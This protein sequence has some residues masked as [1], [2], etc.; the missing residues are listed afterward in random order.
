M[1]EINQNNLCLTIG[2]S[3]KNAPQNYTKWVL[4]SSATDHIT[5]NQSLLII[6]R[7]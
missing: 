5:E 4:D 1:I 7:K 3:T 2:F 6:I